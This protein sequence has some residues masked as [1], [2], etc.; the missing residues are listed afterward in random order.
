MNY[1]PPLWFSRL[2]SLPLL[3]L[4]RL[5]GIGDLVER[6]SRRWVQ[7]MGDK[8]LLDASPR[9]RFAVLATRLPEFRSLIH[10]RARNVSFF[11]RVPM[12]MLFPGEATLKFG[13]ENIGV[14]LFVQ[15]GFATGID[16]VRIGED[17]WIN[18]QVTIGNTTKG[19]P[20]IGD[21]VIICAGAMVLGPITIGDDAII[22]AN[23]TVV[24]DVPP[25]AVFVSPAA[26][27]LRR[28]AHD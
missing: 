17:C 23:A 14:G 28:S 9:D 2:Y 25:G 20:T 3:L 11:L 24:T 6:E 26:V 1:G 22:G 18:Q 19:K 4:V 13:S 5:A 12:R 8:T 21:R 15:H 27:E 10:Y 7:C 16:A